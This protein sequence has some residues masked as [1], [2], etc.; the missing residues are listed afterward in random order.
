MKKY[1]VGFIFNSTLDKVLLIH[2]NRPDWQ[3]GKINGPRGKF[4][5][6][7]DG[8]DCIVREI[9]EETSLETKKEDW[10]YTGNIFTDVMSVEFFAHIHKG[11]VDDIKNMTD[12]PVE[13][14]NVSALPQ[15][16]INNIPWLVLISLDKLKHNEF[17]N[18]SIKYN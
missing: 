6:G 17:E 14:F 7:E 11:S 5:E 10:V 2:K 12:E 18:F 8:F 15:N 9:R 3:A 1:T 13:W 16:T 4:E